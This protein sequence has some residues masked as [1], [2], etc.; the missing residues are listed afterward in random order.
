MERALNFNAGPAA[1]PLEVLQKAQKEWLDFGGTGMSVL[2]MSHRSSEFESILASAKDRLVRLM[3]I[4]D[5]HDILFIQGGASLQF[6]MVPMNLGTDGRSGSYVLTGSWSEKALAEAEKLG[7][8]QIAASSKTGNYAYIPS[9]G[10]LSDFSGAS[11]LHI[12]SNNTIYGTQWKKFPDCGSIPLV[13]D[14]S[15]D[16]LSRAIDVSK[17][18]LIYAGAQK[19][20]GPSGVTVVIIRKDLIGREMKNLPSMLDYNTYH[21]NNSLYNTPPSFAIYLLSLVL[22]WAEEQGGTA[23][24]EQMNE[25]KAGMLYNA[26]DTSGGF[27]K[28]HAEPAHRSLM[29]VTFTLPDGERT[30]RFLSEAKKA[31]FTGLGGHRSIGGCRASIYNAVPSAHVERLITFMEN[32]RKKN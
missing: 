14:M 8:P 1:L 22:E 32:F 15:S 19:N 23:G 13:A 26:I 29:N 20:L 30:K 31:G 27:Y 9:A 7:S 10:S 25:E 16:I 24:L 18:G 3:S 17:F 5:T 21:K 4:P 11:Y 12:T 28:G 6:T 2:E